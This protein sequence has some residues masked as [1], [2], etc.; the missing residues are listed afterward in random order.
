M[1]TY[2]R[3]LN[4]DDQKIIDI[5][6]ID[7]R[8]EVLLRNNALLDVRNIAWGQDFGERG[9]HITTNISPYDPGLPCDFFSTR[10]VVGIRCGGKVLFAAPSNMQ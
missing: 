4:D 2:D 7:E 8:Y 9:F 10:D 6:S 3:S 1:M 5:L